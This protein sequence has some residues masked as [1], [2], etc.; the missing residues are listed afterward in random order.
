M[1]LKSI[2]KQYKVLTPGERVSLLLAAQRRSDEVEKTRLNKNCPRLEYS[3]S[4]YYGYVS[5]LENLS[6]LHFMQMQEFASYFSHF[7][8]LSRT[9]DGQPDQLAKAAKLAKLLLMFDEVWLEFCD[10]LGIDG[11]QLLEPLPGF[12]RVQMLIEEAVKF[13]E[14]EADD[15]K[16]PEEGLP[17]DFRTSLTD[18][19]RRSFDEAIRLWCHMK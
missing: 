15:S 14:S 4:D 5:T 13:L 19:L 10:D 8:Q 11:D 3:I 9:N 1:N 18:Q 16:L 12:E 7:L 6:H 2:T 17:S